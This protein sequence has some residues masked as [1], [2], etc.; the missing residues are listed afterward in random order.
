[1]LD[2]QKTAGWDLY[3]PNSRLNTCSDIRK[4]VGDTEMRLK[5]ARVKMPDAAEGRRR[6]AL[7]QSFDGCS[8]GG[9]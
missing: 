9:E 7:V 1:M 2:G 8:W 5:R 4:L 3:H 6:E